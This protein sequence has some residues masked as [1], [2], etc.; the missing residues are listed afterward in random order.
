MGNLLK[1]L[2]NGEYPQSSLRLGEML[3]A[4][5]AKKS[6]ISLKN[7]NHQ[8]LK[9]I[10]LNNILEQASNYNITET[11]SPINSICIYIAKELDTKNGKGKPNKNLS[12][13]KIAGWRDKIKRTEKKVCD[14]PSG[15]KVSN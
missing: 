4:R 2:V 12:K 9:I 15:K 13:R 6:Q 1:L 7:E 10:K 8:Q 3:I 11:N 5:S 14:R